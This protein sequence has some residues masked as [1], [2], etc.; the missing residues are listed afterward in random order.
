MI[1][2][3]HIYNTNESKTIKFK[4][5]NFSKIIFRKYIF[6]LLNHF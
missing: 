6:Q 4:V 3:I 5:T 2:V 1:S